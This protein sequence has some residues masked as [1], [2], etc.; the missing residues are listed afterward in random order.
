MVLAA[1][2]SFNHF[3]STRLATQVLVLVNLNSICA[4]SLLT[5]LPVPLFAFSVLR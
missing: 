2:T 1:P 4:L 5:A 3:L